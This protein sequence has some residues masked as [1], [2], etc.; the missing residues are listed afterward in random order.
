MKMYKARMMTT[1]LRKMPI[2][3]NIQL[4]VSAEESGVA[5]VAPL[6]LKEMFRQAAILLGKMDSIM[7]IPFKPLTFMVERRATGEGRTT[8]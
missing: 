2:S 3:C 4:S 7:E 8:S 6:S 5:G 1:M